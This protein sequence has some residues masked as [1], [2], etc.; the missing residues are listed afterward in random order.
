MD[1]SELLRVC[2]PVFDRTLI[3]YFVTGSIATSVYGEPR[4]TRD[5][6][7]VVHLES[8]D[9]EIICGCFQEP[10][11]Y[12]SPDAVR[13]AIN[14]ADRFSVIHP[15]SGFKL[16]FK[17]SGLSEFDRSR[18]ARARPMERLPGLL[19]RD[20]SPEDVILKKLE[21]FK[22]GGSEKHI[23]DI[24]GVL[25]MLGESLDKSYTLR[26]AEHL[27]VKDQCTFASEQ[28]AEGSGP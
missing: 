3:G 23:R 24:A 9:A 4:M 13:K 10:E 21:Y 1:P 26:W 2:V 11:F 27:G 16:D 8:A 17:V 22:S 19:V 7:I 5:I 25:R 12:V 14:L 6:D 20:A 15:A 28:A 18:F